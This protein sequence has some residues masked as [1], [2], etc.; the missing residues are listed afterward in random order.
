MKVEFLLYLKFSI[1]VLFKLSIILKS[2]FFSKESAI[3]N[4]EYYITLEVWG[5]DED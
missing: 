1:T 3:R 5:E 2:F 4:T